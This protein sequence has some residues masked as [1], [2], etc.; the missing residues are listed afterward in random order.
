MLGVP[1]LLAES[2]GLADPLKEVHQIIGTI[3]YF[4]IGAHA[5]VGGSLPSHAMSAQTEIRVNSELP[6]MAIAEGGGGAIVMPTT[7]NARMT[8]LSTASATD[9]PRD[10]PLPRMNRNMP[11]TTMAAS[12]KSATGILFH[13]PRPTTRDVAPANGISGR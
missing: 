4:L 12:T 10:S 11:S 8:R 9:L 7:V 5:S 2:K 13:N 1:S 6:A 3:G